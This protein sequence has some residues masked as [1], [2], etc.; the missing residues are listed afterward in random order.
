MRIEINLD[1]DILKKLQDLA[2]KDDRSRKNY[3]ERIVVAHV[4]EKDDEKK[5]KKS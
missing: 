3:I 5:K 1:E 4:K 2:D